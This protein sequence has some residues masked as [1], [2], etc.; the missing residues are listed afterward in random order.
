MMVVPEAGL[1]AQSIHSKVLKCFVEFEWSASKAASNLKKHGISFEE[2][3]TV[4]G[5]PLSYTFADPDHSDDESRFLLVGYSM[6]GKLLTVS[7]TE[8]RSGIRVISARKLTK[9]ERKFYE[10]G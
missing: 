6:A 8:R 5:D 2:A 7:Y 3:T 1:E 9:R 4:F 10:G